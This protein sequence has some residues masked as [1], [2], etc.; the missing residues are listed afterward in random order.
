MSSNILNL[1]QEIIFY[2]ILYFIIMLDALFIHSNNDIY[3]FP[4]S[5]LI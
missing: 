3:Q 5:I 1:I 4:S 2:W